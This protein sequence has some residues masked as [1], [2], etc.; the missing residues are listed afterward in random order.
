MVCGENATIELRQLSFEA[1][2]TKAA[3]Y[4]TSIG[5]TYIITSVVGVKYMYLYT[6]EAFVWFVESLIKTFGEKTTLLNQFDAFIPYLHTVKP[7]EFSSLEFT[8]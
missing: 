5:V 2:N 3:V 8:K 7:I 4:H 1:P 6:P